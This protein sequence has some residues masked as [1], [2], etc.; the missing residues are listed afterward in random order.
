M[1]IGAILLLNTGVFGLPNG[2]CVSAP[3]FVEHTGSARLI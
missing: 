3:F 2:K 1:V